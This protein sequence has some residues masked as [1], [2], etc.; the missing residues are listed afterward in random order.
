[1]TVIA[2]KPKADE[3]IPFQGSSMD[4]DCFASLAMTPLRRWSRR[5]T[6]PLVLLLLLALPGCREDEQGRSI[7]LHKG[8]YAGPP[9]P[10]LSDAQ[11][12]RLQQRA[13][14]DNE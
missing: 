7:H 13:M 3:A 1:M 5:F 8:S 4:R 6:G 2:R 14:H 10:P 12:A 11:V 9:V